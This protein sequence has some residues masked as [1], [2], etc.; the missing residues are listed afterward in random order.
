MGVHRPREI[1]FEALSPI[2]PIF[3]IPR[4]MAQGATEIDFN[5]P[6]LD[7]DCR[8]L[9]GIRRKLNQNATLL[10]AEATAEPAKK[11]TPHATNRYT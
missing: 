10:P 1:L 9:T 8:K 4:P 3:A 5:R 11:L 7:I 6:K 2:F